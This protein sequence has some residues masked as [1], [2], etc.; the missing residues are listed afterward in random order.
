VAAQRVS[1][2]KRGVLR[3]VSTYRSHIG[4]DERAVHG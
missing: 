2:V 4:Q 3:Q 1:G